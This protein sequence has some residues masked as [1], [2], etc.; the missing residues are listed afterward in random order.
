MPSCCSEIHKGIN[1]TSAPDP[2]DCITAVRPWKV[3]IV[4]IVSYPSCISVIQCSTLRQL[5]QS[6]IPKMWRPLARSLYESARTT[7]TLLY[8]STT[9]S[10]G[11]RC[12]TF[13]FTRT[14]RLMETSG[15]SEEQMDV[16]EA[17]GKI[18]SKFPDVNIY[19]L[20]H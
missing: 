14:Y 6:S 13:S 16:R 4:Y 7:P 5:S 18:C 9:R 12:R 19:L 3:E 1:V 10:T 11:L 2:R 8:H 17:V 15:F 20:A